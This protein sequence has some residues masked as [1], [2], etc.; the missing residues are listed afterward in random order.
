[1][2]L[3]IVLVLAMAGVVVGC[4][5][6]SNCMRCHVE[7]DPKN[8]ECQ[9]CFRG[10]VKD[11]KCQLT[12]QAP[13][14]NCAYYAIKQMDGLEFA[15]CHRCDFGFSLSH[16]KCRPCNDPKC[17]VCDATGKCQACFG[18]LTPDTVDPTRCTDSKCPIRNCEVCQF[19]GD[20]PT[21]K[22]HCLACTKNA[23]QIEGNQ[24]ECLVSRIANCALIH[25]VDSDKCIECKE[26]FYITKDS[27][28]KL[29]THKDGGS[30]GWWMWL[31]LVLVLAM[32]A[33]YLYERHY[34][35]VPKE[36]EGLIS[37]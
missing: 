11:R 6:E 20:G 21:R 5:E 12:L 13:I 23:L 3:K 26:G 29:N 16:D 19:E 4:P 24:L 37:G 8:N 18:G 17:A 22:V 10:F 25:E 15:V 1:M 14:D 36:Q 28:C 7:P 32:L 9:L 34:G 2:N 30:K 33:A 31:V 35:F 27:H